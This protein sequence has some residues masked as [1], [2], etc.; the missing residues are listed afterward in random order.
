[1]ATT[2]GALSAVVYR[3][4]ELNVLYLSVRDGNT[5]AAISDSAVVSG[6]PLISKGAFQSARAHTLSLSCSDL[7]DR[8]SPACGGEVTGIRVSRL[9]LLFTMFTVLLLLRSRFSLMTAAKTS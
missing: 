1:M 2:Q 4:A 6:A 5:C 9:H 3:Y 7:S 8:I